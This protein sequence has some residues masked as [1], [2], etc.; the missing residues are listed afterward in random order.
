MLVSIDFSIVLD[1]KS[2]CIQNKNSG[3]INIYSIDKNS[4]ISYKLRFKLTN[5]QYLQI[6]DD[7][8]YFL[9]N[10][11]CL[12]RYNL[13]DQSITTILDQVNQFKINGNKILVL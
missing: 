5:I 11:E 12:T 2:V 10:E 13:N 9:Q 1:S 3:V 4:Q 8:L 6:K 7:N